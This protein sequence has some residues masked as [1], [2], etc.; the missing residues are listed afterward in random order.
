MSTENHNKTCLEIAEIN[1]IYYIEDYNLLVYQLRYNTLYRSK[2][3]MVSSYWGVT[4]CVYSVT[5]PMLKGEKN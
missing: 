5:H 2:T 4:V 1:Y 3:L